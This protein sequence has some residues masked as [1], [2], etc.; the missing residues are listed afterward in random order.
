VTRSKAETHE[1][2]SLSD[3]HLHLLV[4]VQESSGSPLNLNSRHPHTES[5]GGP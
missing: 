4:T 3:D 2:Q 1:L 5:G